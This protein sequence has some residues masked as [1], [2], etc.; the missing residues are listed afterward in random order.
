MK[1]V[2]AGEWFGPGNVPDGIVEVRISTGK[3][4]PGYLLKL[5]HVTL[6]WLS[7]REYGILRAGLAAAN[8]IFDVATNFARSTP[9]SIFIIVGGIGGIVWLFYGDQIYKLLFRGSDETIAAYQ[10]ISR[11]LAEFAGGITAIPRVIV[12]SATGV[13]DSISKAF[14]EFGERFGRLIQI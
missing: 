3:R 6:G 7:V 9:G 4:T 8:R 2:P 1:V 13:F 10:N 14:A 12:E 5:R 11:Q